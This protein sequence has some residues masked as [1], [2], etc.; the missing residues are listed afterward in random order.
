MALHI[1][2]SNGKASISF[3]VSLS[4]NNSR[5]SHNLGKHSSIFIG[6]IYYRTWNNNMAQMVVYVYLF[7]HCN[8]RFPFTSS[9]QILLKSQLNQNKVVYCFIIIIIEQ[10]IDWY[11]YS[12]QLMFGNSWY[13]FF[14]FDLLLVSIHVIW[15]IFDV[16]ITGH[17]CISGGHIW[18]DRH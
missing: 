18:R 1:L 12:F 4:S 7:I 14:F 15:R 17:M 3:Y 13:F 10:S 16:F 5:R 6:I 8:K 9:K 11:S 2:W